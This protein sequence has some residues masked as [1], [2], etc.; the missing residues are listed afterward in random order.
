MFFLIAL[1]LINLEEFFQNKNIR[2]KVLLK[3]KLF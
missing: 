2:L 1:K 3:V